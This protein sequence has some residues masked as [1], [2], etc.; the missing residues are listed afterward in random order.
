[1]PVS[2][3]QPAVAGL[4]T[5]LD[6]D[7]AR[8]FVLQ[9]H[10]TRRLRNTTV[11][12]RIAKLRQLRAA[13]LAHRDAFIDAGVKD[14]KRPAAEVEMFE[15]MPVILD[16]SDTCKRLKRWLKPR[17]VKPTSMTL[18]TSAWVRYEPRG[19]CLLMAPWNYPLTLTFGP[20]VPALA[21]GNAVIIKT[22]EMAPAFSAVMVKIVRETFAEDE[23]AIFEGDA[24]V[25]TTL[26]A[27]PFDH[28]FFTGAPGIGKI[29]MAAAAKHLASV[30]LEL[31]GKCPIIVD[32]TADIDLAVKA[33]AWAKYA[34]SGQTCIAPDHI[35]VHAS[36]RGNFVARFRAR[37]DELYGEGEKAKHAQLG[38]IINARHTQ[39]LV[40]LLD[41][42]RQRGAEILYGGVVDIAEHFVSPTL[43]GNIPADAKIMDEEIFGPL[44][45]IIEYTQIEAVVDAINAA[46]KPLALYIWSRDNA[47]SEYIIANTSAG[48]TCINHQSIQFLHH[49]LPFGGVNNSGIGS[50]HGE[51]GIRA[52]SHE[53]AVVRTNVMLAGIFFPPYTE[54]TRRIVNFILKYL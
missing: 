12:E 37:L 4:T 34:N 19:R 5:A 41:D 50:Y 25:A 52:F 35:Y 30:T 39:R 32:E 54:L 23:V 36:V 1:M 53:R 26:L 22:S 21:C 17:K 42:A 20:L 18:G 27:L 45:P 49:N 11:A 2:A 24:S 3:A 47:R 8:I 29:V 43:I 14:F 7:I 13:I 31:G 51:W 6:G 48:G 28:I 46:P 44:L 38:R 15:L 16:I 10:A 9:G 40:N 33:I